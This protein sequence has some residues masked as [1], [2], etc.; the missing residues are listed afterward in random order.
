MGQAALGLAVA[1]G[2]PVY[3]LAG[4]D[5]ASAALCATVLV[6]RVTAAGINGRPEGDRHATDE[7]LHLCRI[8]GSLFR[9]E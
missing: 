6:L 9:L 7:Q 8:Q 1:V 4:H 2:A 3:V 5:L